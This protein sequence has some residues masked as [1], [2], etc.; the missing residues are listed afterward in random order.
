ME[1]AFVNKKFTQCKTLRTF[2]TDA[3]EIPDNR[4]IGKLFSKNKLLSL[5]QVKYNL[6]P[7]Q[8]LTLQFITPRASLPPSLS[9]SYFILANSNPSSIQFSSC[10]LSVSLFC[11]TPFDHT[12]SQLLDKPNHMPSQANQTF[13]KLYT[14]HNILWVKHVTHQK[15]E[16]LLDPSLSKLD[17][18]V[19][20]YSISNTKYAEFSIK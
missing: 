4:N 7:S 11:P 20:D 10:S 15:A 8:I 18:A 16:S 5:D 1:K 2:Q 9:L 13:I 19:K 14:D 12:L 3:L 6:D 17:N